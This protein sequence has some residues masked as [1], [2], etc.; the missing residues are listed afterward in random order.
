MS[1]P[2]DAE[3]WAAAAAWS[4]RQD[5]SAM[6]T[7][8]WR[9]E[10]HPVQSS[11]SVHVLELD[12][13]PDWERFVAA[14]EWGTKLVTR[15]RQRVVEPTLPTT[16][17][18]WATDQHFRLDYHVRRVSAATRD[19]AL[20]LASAVA[21]R[22]FD[23]NRP[24]WEGLL[25]D[26]L[27]DGRAVWVL[28]FHHALADPL[29]AMQLMSFLQSRTREHSDDKPTTFDSPV[30]EVPDPLGLATQGLLHDV[31]AIP[32]RSARLARYGWAAAKNPRAALGSGLHYAASLRR[33][34]AR[35]PA[36]PSPLLTGRDGR[37]WRFVTST[38][39]LED[40]RAA[41]ALSGGSLQD[42]TVAVV[43]SA[44]RRYHH[45]LGS[46]ID[47]L[48]VSVR[49]SLDRADD[50]GN[51][52]AAAMIAAPVGVEDPIDRIAAVRGEVL[53]LHTERALDAFSAF[54]PVAN[55]LPAAVGATVL[56]T[57]APADAFVTT[58]PGPARA[59]Y[60]AGSQVEAIWS[61]GPL[62]GTALTATLVSY[63]DMAF[64]G[65]NVDAAAV[66]VDLF[67][68]CL[69]EGVDEVA[70]ATD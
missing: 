4:S 51:R 55:R 5:L 47:E 56:A 27:E 62:P 54:A 57:G 3:R 36:P 9:S 67:R 61:F 31:A 53:S 68:Q 65:V 13:A 43:L 16:A 41:A 18:M 34:V 2:S 32:S 64:L 48:P 10:R 37:A 63:G 70:T 52:Y 46:P 69:A 28:K 29:G 26:G 60:L 42:A 35:Q 39:P 25:I 21:V 24:L 49:V 11:T 30:A 58:L 22:P 19:E 1:A 40:L 38:C 15:L 33:L 12:R 6:E 66:D 50:L 23:R 14:H 45:A 44:L 17:P 20:E 7:V 8:L 59:T